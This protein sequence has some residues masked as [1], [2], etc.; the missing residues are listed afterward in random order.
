MTQ[1]AQAIKAINDVL[2]GLP[3]NDRLAS[4]A[5]SILQSEP[6]ATGGLAAMASVTAALSKYLSPTQRMAVALHMSRVARELCPQMP[7]AVVSRVR[8]H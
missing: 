8:L 7:I 1:D 3:L 2:V 6:S 4:L 5:L